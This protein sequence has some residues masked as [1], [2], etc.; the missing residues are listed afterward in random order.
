MLYTRCS[1]GI[2]YNKGKV[3][4]A[5]GLIHMSTKKWEEYS[6]DERMMVKKSVEVYDIKK[7]TWRLGPYLNLAK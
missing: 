7:N 5:G 6:K 4:C 2:C 3:Y 1:H